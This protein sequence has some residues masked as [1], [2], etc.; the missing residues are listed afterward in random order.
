MSG[1]N[2]RRIKGAFGK[3]KH[4]RPEQPIKLQIITKK[5]EESTGLI[6]KLKNWWEKKR[7]F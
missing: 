1:T 3:P 4:L 6:S 5:K 2:K 7:G